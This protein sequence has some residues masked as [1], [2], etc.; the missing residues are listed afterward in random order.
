MAEC[1]CKKFNVCEYNGGVKA[2]PLKG[3]E[4]CKQCLA[5]LRLGRLVRAI[6]VGSALIHNS[7]DWSVRDYDDDETGCGLTPEAAIEGAGK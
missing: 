3:V 1:T 2:P 7:K 4:M 6:E 5:D